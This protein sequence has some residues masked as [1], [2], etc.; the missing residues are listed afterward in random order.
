MNYFDFINTDNHILYNLNIQVNIIAFIKFY[1]FKFYIYP[2]KIFT[3]ISEV[4][5]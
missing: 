3:Q 1:F 2:E 4:K 5:L